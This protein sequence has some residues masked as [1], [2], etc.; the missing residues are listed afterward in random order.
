[1]LGVRV[2]HFAV[3]VGAATAASLQSYYR[4]PLRLSVAC[5]ATGLGSSRIG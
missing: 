3:S 4:F 2:S 1:M 5:T